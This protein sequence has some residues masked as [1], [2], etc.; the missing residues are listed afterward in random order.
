MC[1]CVCSGVGV[2]QNLEKAEER[3]HIKF[4][5]V[6]QWW[7]SFRILRGYWRQSF[8]SHSSNMPLSFSLYCL[9]PP[10]LLTNFLSHMCLFLVLPFLCFPKAPKNSKISPFK[11]RT[12]LISQRNSDLLLPSCMGVQK[13]QFLLHVH[14]ISL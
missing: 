4:I 2:G 10:L 3:H 5:W 6:D 11:S 13:S 1:V 7:P 9:F 14:E 12:Y 8:T